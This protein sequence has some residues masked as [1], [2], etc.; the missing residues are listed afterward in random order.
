MSNRAIVSRTWNEN[1]LHSALLELTYR[2]NLDCFF[3]YNDTHLQGTPLGL[4]EY[5]I[6]LRDLADLQTM[7]LTL[8]GGEPL[9][10]PD[11]FAIGA[12][13]RELGF[14]VRIKSNGH[15][16]RGALARRVKEKVDP[17]IVDASLHGATPEVH[18]RQTRIPGSFVRLMSNLE[19]MQ[20]LGL[21]IRL[22]C[23]L[24][25]WNEHQIE[26]MAQL[27]ER[28]GLPLVMNPTVTPR[29]DG[30]REP[31]SIAPSPATIRRLFEHRFR[32]APR[33][34]AT[35]AEVSHKTPEPEKNCGA[36]SS[37]VTVDPFGNVYPCVQW[38]RPIG[39]LHRQSIKLI[40]A[41]SD[42]LDEIRSIT[43]RAK[44]RK[45]ELGSIGARMNFCPGLSQ[46]NTGDP[47]GIDPGA[48]R[49][50]EILDDFLA[51]RSQG[52]LP[53]IR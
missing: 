7:N 1:I 16:V 12:M 27:A 14:V 52:R 37:S 4:G 33:E 48:L 25:S 31:L 5:E 28:L 41:G 6:L 39:N 29:D 11:F 34:P 13:A 35:A 42:D 17:F 26:E 49:E 10:H 43:V 21:R 18:D 9:A 15:A 36:G 45:S 46:E 44:Q 40:W 3:C 22:N 32:D 30:D 50:A 23:T 47:L 19:E 53:I 20:Q 51:G 8:S 24:T 38:R 2:C